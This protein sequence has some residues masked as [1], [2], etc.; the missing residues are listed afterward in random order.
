M[1]DFCVIRNEIWFTVNEC[2]KIFNYDIEKRKLSTVARFPGVILNKANLFSSVEYY[3]EKIFFIPFISDKVYIYNIKNNE[4]ETIYLSMDKNVA[5][6]YCSCFIDHNS[7]YLIPI[8]RE[9]ILKINMDTYTQEYVWHIK[10]YLKIND[11]NKTNVFF[12]NQSCRCGENLINFI[13]ETK[14]IL[15]LNLVKQKIRIK[16]LDDWFQNIIAICGN[17]N[18]IFCLE[19]ATG[20]LIKW[21]IISDN[22][23]YLEINYEN[24]DTNSVSEILNIR[25]QGSVYSVF[26]DNHIYLC[27]DLGS[28]CIEIDMKTKSAYTLIENGAQSS[29]SRFL[30]SKMHLAHGKINF[31]YGA[32]SSFVTIDEKDL[33]KK[34]E[35]LLSEEEIK[36]LRKEIMEEAVMK[37]D[38][39]ICDAKLFIEMNLKQEKLSDVENAGN[40]IFRKIKGEC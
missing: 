24:A 18:D 40:R 36:M 12:N 6:N 38:S 27:P 10:K 8:C 2:N 3:N 37:E 25:Y 15:V 34:E 29:D 4:F 28:V 23:T 31:F 17:G 19:R 20:N 26:R 13:S 7:L 14:I 22:I 32:E 1:H 30:N 11:K 21:N 39:R 5:C 33:I 9:D 16:R 35:I